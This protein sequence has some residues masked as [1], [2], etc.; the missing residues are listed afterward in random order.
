MGADGGR[1]NS[2]LI[3]IMTVDTEE[4][5]DWGAGFSRE[6]FTVQNTE[7]IPKF[8]DFCR[9]L[10]VRPTYF[11]DY[12][13]VSD[14]PSVS[15]FR[16]FHD[17]GDCEIGAH[18]HTWVT[19][20]VEEEIHSEN[21]HAVN[22]P[23]ELVRRKLANLTRKLT[24]AFGT[25]PVSF[26]SG[27]W[28][29][30]GPLLKQLAEAGYE[31]D[32]SVHPFY[33]DSTFSYFDAPEQPYWPDFGDCATPG[34]QRTVFEIP[35]TSGFNRPDFRGCHRL[36]ERLAQPP[37]SRLRL[38]GGLWHLRLMRKIPLS[39][40]LTDGPNMIS[41]VDACARR[42]HTVLNMFL[43]SSSLLP[44]ASPYVRDV[45]EEAE[46]YRRT[47]EVVHHLKQ[48]FDVRFCTL[49]EAKQLYLQEET[50]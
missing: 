41:L 8:Q 3:F 29:M 45:A 35:V 40:E 20:P 30:N 19:P 18:L 23:P 39:P 14:A 17:N 7:Y 32:S 21:T 15:R 33:A 37:L 25:R 28:G 1:S 47:A 26:R 50:E 22:L 10:G 49:S 38:I 44:G 12:A 4:E 16:G 48:R 24:E 6:G 42:G 9:E 11:V 36:Q 43:H 2:P 13:I 5:W 34:T 27:R 31:T 46:F